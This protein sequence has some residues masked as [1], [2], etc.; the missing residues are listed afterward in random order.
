MLT[1]VAHEKFY[2][3]WAVIQTKRPYSQSIEARL[4]IWQYWY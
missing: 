3:L 2:N 1:W 4:I